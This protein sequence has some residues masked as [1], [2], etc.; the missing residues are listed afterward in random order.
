MAPG[1]VPQ[2]VQ[3]RAPDGRPLLLP[4]GERD[5]MPALVSHWGPWVHPP[6]QRAQG[7]A[8]KPRWM[9]LPEWREAQGIKTT[10]RRRLVR[11]HPRVV[12]GALAAVQQGLAAWRG[13][14]AACQDAVQ[15]RGWRAAAV[16]AV[17]DLREL[18]LVPCQLTPALAATPPGPRDGLSHMLVALDTS[19]GGGVD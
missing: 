9:P 14:G 6:R 3:G 5:S 12:F 18:L 2:G 11:G 7:P 1:M 16:E 8:P 19:H 4:A 10:R 17:S 13:G 15:G